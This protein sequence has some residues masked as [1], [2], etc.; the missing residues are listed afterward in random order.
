[1]LIISGSSLIGIS[2]RKFIRNI[3]KNDKKGIV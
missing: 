2:L 3:F 1:M